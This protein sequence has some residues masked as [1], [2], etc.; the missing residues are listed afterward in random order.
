M[1]VK[2]VGKVYKYRF[3][4][5]KKEYKGTC[6]NCYTKQQADIFEGEIK[7]EIMDRAAGRI[8]ESKTYTLKQGIKLYK[9]HI[10]NLRSNKLNYRYIDKL[11][12]YIS[13]AKS[14]FTLETPLI[15]ISKEKARIYR[16]W[17][18][19]DVLVTKTGKKINYTRDNKTV[20][21]YVSSLSAL[22]N[23][24]LSEHKIPY[25][26]LA[27]LEPLKIKPHRIRILKQTE[28]ENIFALMKSR[29]KYKDLLDTTA[30]K[31]ASGMR[32]GEVFKLEKKYIDLEARTIDLY[33][34]K[35]NSWTTLS[36]NEVMFKIIVERW[37]NGSEYIFPSKITG[38]PYTNMYKSWHKILKLA[39]IED[40]RG[41]DLRR[42]FATWLFESGVSIYV[43]MTILGHTNVE[44]TRI[45]LG[46]SKKILKEAMKQADK[47]LKGIYDEREIR[48]EVN[49]QNMLI[50]SQSTDVNTHTAECT[51]KCP[52]V[53]FIQWK[54]KNTDK[55]QNI[56]TVK[57]QS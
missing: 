35:T 42:T 29:A 24:A 49:T 37:N 46:I 41:H 15:P 6:K 14:A 18:K 31:L 25:N 48:E 28:K 20:N 53:N 34:E 2:K 16:E 54:S 39:G 21:E 22:I 12:K 19:Y 50:T 38:K 52:V 56:I 43:I 55:K 13:T 10:K 36:I 26:P 23:F 30:M 11:V 3:K 5:N 27:K 17:L 32:Q 45:Y 8:D 51:K 40:L 7:K 44:T 9:T 4:I 57:K 47:K 33:R 1:T